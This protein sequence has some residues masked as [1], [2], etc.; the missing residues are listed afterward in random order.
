MSAFMDD[1][2]LLDTYSAAVTAAVRKIRPAVV[3]IAVEREGAPAGSGSGFVVTPD[4]YVAHQQPR[5]LEG[6]RVRG[7]P[8]RRAR[9]DRAAAW[10]TT[11]IP[12]SR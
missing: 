6:D 10:A 11:P 12:T 9:D 1:T 5:G 3:H 8:A 7:E 4:G 2:A